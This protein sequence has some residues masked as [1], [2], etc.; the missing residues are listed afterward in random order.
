MGSEKQEGSHTDYVEYGIWNLLF[1]SSSNVF[2]FDMLYHIYQNMEYVGSDE[3]VG[4]HEKGQLCSSTHQVF[5][6]AL[7]SP[8]PTFLVAL[9]IPQPIPYIVRARSHMLICQILDSVHP[10]RY[11]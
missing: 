9:H 7:R 2:M 3:R 4:S 1:F 10:T 6:C 8:K 11:I 5:L